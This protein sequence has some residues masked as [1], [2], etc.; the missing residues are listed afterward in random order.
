MVFPVIVGSG[1][2]LFDGIPTTTLRLGAATTTAT[3][4]AILTYVPIPDQAP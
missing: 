2:R 4:V 3:G 1:K